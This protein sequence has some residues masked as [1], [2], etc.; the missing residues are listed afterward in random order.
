MWMWG[1][2]KHTPVGQRIISSFIIVLCW[3]QDW[4]SLV[5]LLFFSFPKLPSF[6]TKI[7]K[8]FYISI[9]NFWLFKLWQCVR[10]LWLGKVFQCWPW[11]RFFLFIKKTFVK[12][13]THTYSL[14]YCSTCPTCTCVWRVRLS[15]RPRA[16]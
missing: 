3:P 14:A 9:L 10:V 12:T 5:F 2:V 7:N 6:T 15:L 11:Q 8:I 1:S 13:P 4:P 16:P